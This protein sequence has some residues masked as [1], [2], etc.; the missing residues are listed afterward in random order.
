MKRFL[1]L[2]GLILSGAAAWATPAPL[3][4]ITL[5]S[6]NGPFVNGIPT[7]PYT[8]A[9]NPLVLVPAMCD[10]YYHDG[11]PGD[12]WYAY[13]TSVAAPNLSHMR[14]G[15]QGIV[16]YEEVSWL[17][18]QTYSTP[19]SQWADI[20]YAVW[21]IFNP[22]V[23]IDANSQNWINLAAANYPGVDYSEVWIA[24]PLQINAPPTGDQEFVFLWP[25]NTPP[26]LPPVPEPPTFV[27]LGTLAVAEVM[28]RRHTN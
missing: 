20:N 18:L 13:L 4:V 9:L 12:R 15:N 1:I 27:L 3:G 5:V 26:P 24:T 16:P 21:H 23:P 25:F 28:R 19:P 14:F 17:F 7:Y 10:D 11:T 8:L 6:F 2:A 22:T